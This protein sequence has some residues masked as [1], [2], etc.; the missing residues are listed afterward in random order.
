MRRGPVARTADLAA[1]GVRER[2]LT[3]AVRA[4]EVVRLR[5]G[6]YALPDVPAVFRHATAHGGVPGC[7]EAARLHGLW[8]LDGAADHVW[9]GD[10]GT[11]HGSCAAS[12]TA[13]GSAACRVHWDEGVAVIGELPPVHNVLLQMSQC[14][15]EEA[16]FAAYESAL[17]LSK[18]SPAGIAWLW[19]HLPVRMR[20][21]LDIARSDA[22]SGLESLVRL[23]LHLLGVSVRTQFSIR[24]VGEVDILI[25]DRLLIECDGREN[26][27]R[28][29]QRHKDLL[30]DAAAAALGYETLR[31]DYALIVH[32]WCRV[33]AA[34]I[35]KIE[36]R[37][38]LRTPAPASAVGI[39]G[40]SGPVR[41]G[42][43]RRAAS[44]ALGLRLPTE[45]SAGRAG[46]R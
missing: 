28:E 44:S 25:G 22:D 2:E 27:E 8:V 3:R 26:H 11:P 4:G 45:I 12:A 7:A 24:G 43:A 5:Q 20:W 35:A 30:R 41:R 36:A 10:G 18:I 39:A 9:M 17:R 23:R 38:H 15:S 13:G 33:E 29:Q 31:F 16:F 40:S 21:M 46:I 19:R 37:A 32:D 14:E 6:V 1:L 42:D 34:I